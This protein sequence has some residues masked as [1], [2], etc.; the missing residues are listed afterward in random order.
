MLTWQLNL[1][2]KIFFP[3]NYLAKLHPL[4]RL[5][6]EYLYIFKTK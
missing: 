4:F 1:D 6:Y 2:Y 3:L 5:F